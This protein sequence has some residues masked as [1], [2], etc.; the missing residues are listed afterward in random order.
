MRFMDWL[1]EV[2]P[3]EL[4]G[5]RNDP[6]RYRFRCFLPYLTRLAT[7]P[8]ARLPRRIWGSS[9]AKS[10]TLHIVTDARQSDGEAVERLAGPDLAGKAR[11]AGDVEGEVEHVFLPLAGR[12]GLWEVPGV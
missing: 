9:G 11:V 7:T 1:L 2:C 10:T 6:V 3:S 12:G 5:S 4:G 8:S